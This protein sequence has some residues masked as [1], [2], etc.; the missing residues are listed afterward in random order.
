MKKK[1]FKCT[2][3]SCIKIKCTKKRG[4]MKKKVGKI[5]NG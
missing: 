4:Q 5:E 3:V 2:I 1:Y